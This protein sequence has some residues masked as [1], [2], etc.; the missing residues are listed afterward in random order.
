MRSVH[1]IDGNNVG[2]SVND[3]SHEGSQNFHNTD[4]ISDAPQSRSSLDREFFESDTYDDV[5]PPSAAYPLAPVSHNPYLHHAP[6]SRS[7]VYND[8]ASVVDYFAPLSTSLPP[9]S[10]Q[11]P[12]DTEDEFLSHDYYNIRVE[13]RSYEYDDANDAA[14]IYSYSNYDHIPF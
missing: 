7:E 6:T 10:N 11:P 2:L 13:T 14:G 9:I 5:I 3:N 1:T 4:F 8:T 12:S